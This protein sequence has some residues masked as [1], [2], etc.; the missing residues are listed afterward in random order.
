[1]TRKLFRLAMVGLIGCA[2]IAPLGGCDSA[3][4]SRPTIDTSTPIKAPSAPS[5]HKVELKPVAKK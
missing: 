2:L 3:S 5:V 4:Q 1:M